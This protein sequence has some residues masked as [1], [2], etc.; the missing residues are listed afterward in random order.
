MHY[1]L[2]NSMT[3]NQKLSNGPELHDLRL[4]SSVARQSSFVAAAREFNVA[5]TFVSKR[6]SALERAI[7]ARLL[8]RTT[9]QV[10]LTDEGSKVY[11]WAQKIL[12]DIEDM[13]DEVSES[14]RDPGGALRISSSAKLG[15]VHLAPALA[16]FKRRYPKIEV[17]LELL[18]R[19]ADL[20]L[21]GFHLDIRAGDIQEPHLIAH[22]I[23]PSSRILCAAPAYLER[24]GTPGSMA[25]LAHHECVLLRDREEPFGTWRMNGPR[26]WET[27]KVSGSM[28][29]ND[30]DAVL[31]WARSGHGIAC[32]ADWLFAEGLDDGSLVRVLPDHRQP[33][34][35]W[36]ASS[37]RSNQSARV[38]LCLEFLKAHM[39][40]DA[41]HD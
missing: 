8:N 32:S 21:E 6:V 9:R 37:A 14:T 3:M 28:A 36:A 17:W 4:F 39:Q 38:R 12:E 20:I 29:S 5:P 34:D 7:G 40:P 19:R 16:R 24:H 1:Q 26:G 10:G 33:A 30:I 23:M 13:H 35:V 22:R 11:A 41:R 31:E 2:A 18:D 25:E 15:R 27:V